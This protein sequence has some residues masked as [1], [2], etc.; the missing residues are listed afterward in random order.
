MV[1]DL[2]VMVRPVPCLTGNI[3]EVDLFALIHGQL[4]G[5]ARAPFHAF[6]VLFQY[7]KSIDGM[8]FFGNLIIALQ[9]LKRVKMTGHPFP[10]FLNCLVKMRVGEHQHFH[11]GRRDEL[12]SRMIRGN[13]DFPLHPK[14]F[15]H[16]FYQCVGAFGS[17]GV[18]HIP[19]PM[20][21]CMA[22]R[23]CSPIMSMSGSGH[24]LWEKG[25]RY[26]VPQWSESRLGSTQMPKPNQ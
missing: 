2:V 24:I 8:R 4:H 19:W 11:R 25:N 26:R 17:P 6:A 5:P 10:Q 15:S 3:E 7:A 22:S 1:V 9:Q 16:L 18:H 20:L 21:S 12:S 23:S 14:L 13:Q